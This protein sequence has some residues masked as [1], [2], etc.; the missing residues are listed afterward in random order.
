MPVF[1][2]HHVVC[3][4]YRETGYFLTSKCMRLEASYTRTR[5]GELTALARRIAEL[6]ALGQIHEGSM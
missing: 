2:F 4:L 5:M 3:A 6:R 1:L